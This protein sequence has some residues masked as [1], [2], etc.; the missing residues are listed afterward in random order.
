MGDDE[1]LGPASAAVAP[2][3][4]ALKCCMI[5]SASRL[6]HASTNASWIPRPSLL[7]SHAAPV[8]AE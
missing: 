4:R 3:C 2:A 5:P 8:S 7:N 1:A 6:K